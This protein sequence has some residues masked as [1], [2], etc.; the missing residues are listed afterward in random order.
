MIV[1]F[2]SGLILSTLIGVLIGVLLMCAVI[3]GKQSEERSKSND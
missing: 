1:L 2:L 3:C